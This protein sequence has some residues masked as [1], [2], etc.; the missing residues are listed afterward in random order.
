VLYRVAVSLCGSREDAE[1]IVQEAYA[2][3]LT[4]ERWINEDEVG[5]LVR[6]VRNVFLSHCAAR[7]RRPQTVC[8]EAALEWVA[9]QQSPSVADILENRGVLAV[10]ADLPDAHREVLVAV[11]VAGLSYKEAAAELGVP[12]G[13]VMSRLYRARER[14]VAALT[15]A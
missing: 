6:T 9:D 8:D 11:D 7:A 10:I 14:V 15:P 3:V 4:K 13:T 5:Y 12:I 2:R 1:D